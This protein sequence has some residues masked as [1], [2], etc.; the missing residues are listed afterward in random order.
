LSDRCLNRKLNIQLPEKYKQNFVVST[1]YAN[2]PNIHIHCTCFSCFSII[3][4]IW[5]SNF[6]TLAVCF[7]FAFSYAATS[8]PFARLRSEIYSPACWCRLSVLLD[9]FSRVSTS[10]RIRDFS[11]FSRLA[12][13]YRSA[14]ISSSLVRSSANVMAGVA[15]VFEASPSYIK[16]IPIN[17]YYYP[18][19]FF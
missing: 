17:Y 13:S 11:F 8:A 10:S 5:D 2:I 15:D 12:A 4:I 16:T 9:C 3:A 19:S 18:F 6:F 14:G 1:L 7:F